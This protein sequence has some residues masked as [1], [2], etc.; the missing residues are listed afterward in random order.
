[1]KKRLLYRPLRMVRWLKWLIWRTTSRFII[2]LKMA[3]TLR[4][5]NIRLI[6]LVWSVIHINRFLIDLY[7]GYFGLFNAGEGY[8]TDNYP[9][10]SNHASSQ[11][12]I[13]EVKCQPKTWPHSNRLFFFLSQE[14]LD[15]FLCKNLNIH[16]I[17]ES[18]IKQTWRTGSQLV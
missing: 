16:Y 13:A 6:Y 2:A 9:W 12:N 18:M 5:V 15:W 1:M 11:N 8:K 4:R 3:K 17:V 10:F 14:R 7:I